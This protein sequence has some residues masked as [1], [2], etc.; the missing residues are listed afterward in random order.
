[1][2]RAP[3]L[4][5]LYTLHLFLSFNWKSLLFHSFLSCQLSFH[6]TLAT[7]SRNMP[8]S[9]L[10]SLAA[11]AFF[12]ATT[13]FA[14]DQCYYLDGQPAGGVYRCD[15][16]TSGDSSCCNAGQICYS[17]GVC[18][19]GPEND[20]TDWLRVGCTDP[21]WSSPACLKQCITRKHLT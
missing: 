1:M 8:F 19:V 20:A 2:E 14:G 3:N 7:K 17:N 12:L 21:T 9:K 5:L 16:T 18:Q 11:L 13:V 6:C 15:N 10:L 4:V